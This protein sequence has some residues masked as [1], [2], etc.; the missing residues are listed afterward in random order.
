MVIGKYSEIKLFPKIISPC[1]SGKHKIFGII[2][3]FSLNQIAT[4]FA[5]KEIKF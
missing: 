1:I 5:F 2:N 4:L 3:F